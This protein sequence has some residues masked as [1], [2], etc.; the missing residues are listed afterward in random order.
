MIFLKTSA[1]ALV[2]LSMTVQCQQD[3]PQASDENDFPS[4]TSG[5]APSSA[6]TAGEIL[7]NAGDA[8]DAVMNKLNNV[9][10]TATDGIIPVVPP[11]VISNIGS[12]LKGWAS[13]NTT[14]GTPLDVYRCVGLK[15]SQLCPGKVA[16]CAMGDDACECKHLVKIFETCFSTEKLNPNDPKCG[17]EIL[18]IRNRMLNDAVGKCEAKKLAIDNWNPKLVAVPSVPSNSSTPTNQTVTNPGA[19]EN[20]QPHGA[21]SSLQLTLSGLLSVLAAASMVF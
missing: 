4:T 12:V 13:G 17:E 7:A 15:E 20:E 10:Q 18:N 5:D 14:T 3:S 8:V 11:D 2:L 6:P 1:L 16:A 19:S 21:A 9:T